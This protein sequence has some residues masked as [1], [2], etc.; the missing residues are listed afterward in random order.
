LADAIGPIR[1]LRVRASTV[2]ALSV[3]ALP[4]W[5][6]PV[7]ASRIRTLPVR[8][9]PIRALRVRALPGQ[10]LPVRTLS[11]YASPGSAQVRQERSAGS[12]GA[13]PGREP[14]ALDPCAREEARTPSA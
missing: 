4:V 14:E 6:S 13:G 1:A 10:A 2:R 3:R 11:V 9:L 8:A 12:V 7:R 5:T